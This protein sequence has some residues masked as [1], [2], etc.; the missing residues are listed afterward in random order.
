M[1]YGLSTSIILLKTTLMLHKLEEY[2]TKSC[3][4]VS[5]KKNLFFISE[6]STFIREILPNE[7]GVFGCY[8]HGW[9]NPFK[10]AYLEGP[11]GKK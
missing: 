5:D 3:S 1:G 4:P 2:F 8:K 10:N 7:F 6:N 11:L 9:I